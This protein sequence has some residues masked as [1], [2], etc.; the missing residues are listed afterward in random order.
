MQTRK[1]LITQNELDSLAE[2]FIQIANRL[3]ELARLA[4]KYP[5]LLKLGTASGGMLSRIEDNVD[6]AYVEGVF[7]T[8]RNMLL[9]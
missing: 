2:R 6:R 9:G 8:E 1:K 3:K 4:E 7:Q 5:L